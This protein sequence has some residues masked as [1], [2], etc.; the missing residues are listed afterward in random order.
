MTMVW[1]L[2][3]GLFSFV[4]NI[5]QFSVVQTLSPSATAFGGNFNKAAL[6]FLTLLMPFMGGDKLPGMPYIAVIWAA[7]I[8]NI[9]AFGLYSYLQIQAK[10]EEEE[11]KARKIQERLANGDWSS[12][13]EALLDADGKPVQ[14]RRK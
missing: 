2:L 11:E 1:L 6:I 7:V 10:R 3:S 13:D 12:E 5:I 9:A 8:V 4:Y 14:R